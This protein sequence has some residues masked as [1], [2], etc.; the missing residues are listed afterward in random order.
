[1][2]VLF[3][4]DSEFTI[5][6]LQLS[7][8]ELV[9]TENAVDDLELNPPQLAKALTKLYRSGY[10]PTVPK[11]LF[12]RELLRLTHQIDWSEFLN[13]GAVQDMIGVLVEISGNCPPD[14]SAWYWKEM[15]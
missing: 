10:D 7:Q 12:V 13:D 3:P 5:H 6:Q 1:V 9:R 2:V 8:V 14:Q 4:E 15:F 11:A